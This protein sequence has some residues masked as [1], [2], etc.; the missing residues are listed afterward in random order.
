MDSLD[1]LVGAGAA[2]SPLILLGVLAVL[3]LIDST[4]FGTL[5]IPV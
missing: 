3:A 4:S 5:L 2:G 1:H